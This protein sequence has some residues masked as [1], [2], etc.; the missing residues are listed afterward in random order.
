[1]DS[2]IPWHRVFF[3]DIWGQPVQGSGHAR[4][5]YR[6]LTVLSFRLNKALNTLA[7]QK[8]LSVQGFR[9]F[10]V[11]LHACNVLLVFLMAFPGLVRVYLLVSK[12]D[13]EVL[14]WLLSN[15]EAALRMRLLSVFVV[16]DGVWH[17]SNWYNCICEVA[18]SDGTTVVCLLAVG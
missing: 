7:G 3:S 14:P 2:S 18:A 16:D 15:V 4:K 17:F 1:M 13:H 6:P 9:Q 11:V 5:P 10:N 12:D 8:P